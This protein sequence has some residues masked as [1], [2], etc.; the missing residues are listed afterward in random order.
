MFQTGTRKTK[1][2]IFFRKKHRDHEFYIFHEHNGVYSFSNEGD[3]VLDPFMGSGTTA[4]ECVKLNRHFL[5]FEISDE[6]Q[7]MA[8]ERVNAIRPPDYLTYDT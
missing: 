6:Y 7:K 3:L 1:E 5:G 4:L 8:T 2:N